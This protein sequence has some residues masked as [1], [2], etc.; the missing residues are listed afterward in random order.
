[1]PGGEKY[2][3]IEYSKLVCKYLDIE[4]IIV[5]LDDTKWDEYMQIACRAVGRPIPHFNM[6]PLFCMYKKLNE[7]GEKRLVLGDGPDEVMM[8]YTRD[9]VISYLYRVYQFEAFRNYKPMIDKILPPINV[10]I[11]RVIE[12]ETDETN[13][14]R[15]DIDLM[16]PDMDAMSDGIAK[17]FGITNYRPYQDNKEIDNF[18]YCLPE[19]EKIHEVE[20]GKYALR[21]ITEKYLPKEIAWRKKKVGGPVYP[22]NILRGWMQHGEFDKREYLKYQEQCLTSK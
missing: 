11:S 13:I 9:L 16:R 10:A 20:F 4:H 7:L 6:F 3:E 15:A 18:M 21:K 19:K 5:E 2:N 22:V 12:K 1:L 8:G 17:Y 14:N